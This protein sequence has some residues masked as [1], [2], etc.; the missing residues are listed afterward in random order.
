MT[1]RGSKGV[2]TGNDGQHVATLGQSADLGGR[3][4]NQERAGSPLDS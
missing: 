2:R 3:G 1:L 4:M